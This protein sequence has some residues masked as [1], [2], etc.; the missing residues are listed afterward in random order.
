[1]CLT[2]PWRHVLGGKCHLLTNLR[3]GLFILG[4]HSPRLLGQGCVLE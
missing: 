1:M 3:D 2:P 4:S